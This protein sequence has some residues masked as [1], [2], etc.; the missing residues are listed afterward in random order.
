MLGHA[1]IGCGRIAAN[2]ADAFRA[3]ASVDLTHAIDIDPAVSAAFAEAHGIA[4]AG[5]TVEA[6]LEAAEVG[7]V[8][9]CLPH[10][11]HRPV[12][13]QALQRGK[14]VLVEKPGGI[15]AQELRDIRAEAAAEGLVAMQVAQ[16]RYD[17]LVIAVSELLDARALGRICLVR[18]HLE[19]QRPATYYTD[20]PWRGAWGTEGGSI[21]INQAYHVVDLLLWLAG[22]IPYADARMTTLRAPDV[23]ETEDTLV[24]TLGFASGALGTLTLT[25]AGGANWNS[26]V[27]IIGTDGE[28]AF[29]I[30][31]PNRLHRFRLTER[32]EMRRW[33]RR[34]EAD[35]AAT[36]DAPAGA[37]YY[38]VS[39]R[40][41]AAA[42]V[43]RILGEPI[44][45][46][47]AGMD[48]AVEVA[49]L[50]DRLYAAARRRSRR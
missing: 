32:R 10:H 12:A 42:F 40:K 39:H 30:N 46:T 9:I 37:A 17:P 45:A 11:L 21:L 4:K 50:I 13:I 7:S 24:A 3:L 1:I 48:H 26:Y 31:Y 36:D 16:H 6:A 2:H 34:L 35:L 19:C 41:Q 44:A 38:G 8:S 27:E 22:P 43:A 14:H 29:D 33:R 23:M 47:A 5:K 28:I 25:G 18:G 15:G 20:S 49:S